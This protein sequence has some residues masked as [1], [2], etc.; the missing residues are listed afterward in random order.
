MCVRVCMIADSF[1]SFLQSFTW[2]A[3]FSARAHALLAL[4]AKAVKLLF[5]FYLL[6]HF[7]RF[8]GFYVFFFFFIF[9]SPVAFVANQQHPCAFC[10]S[11]F[12]RISVRTAAL[13]TYAPVPN[14]TKNGIKITS[15]L[16]KAR[17]SLFS[18]TTASAAAGEKRGIPNHLSV[19]PPSTGKWLT[20]AWVRPATKGIIASRSFR[21]SGTVPSSCFLTNKQR[22]LNCAFGSFASFPI[23]VLPLTNKNRVEPGSVCKKK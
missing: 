3:F 14:K 6:F 11:P 10:P 16:Q 12:S 4:Y 5:Y 9:L 23:S 8:N 17:E 13:I 19:C 20:G 18:N 21:P 7:C 2:F 22:N 15:R 1:C